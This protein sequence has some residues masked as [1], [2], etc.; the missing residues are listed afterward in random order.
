MEYKISSDK[1]EAARRK[2]ALN[3]NGP[4][5]EVADEAGRYA[6]MKVVEL[7][8]TD[9]KIRPV[10]EVVVIHLSCEDFQELTAIAEEAQRG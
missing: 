7:L 10:D 5:N 4:I 9:L 6:I 2:G 1:M 3:G 8:H